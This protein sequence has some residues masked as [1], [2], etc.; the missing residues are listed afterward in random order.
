MYTGIQYTNN[1]STQLAEPCSETST[2]LVVNNNA[3]S[4]F[5]KLQNS[6]DY[7]TLTLADTNGN[8][9]I[10]KCIDKTDTTFTVVRAQEGTVAKAFPSGS[11]VE[12]RLTAFGLNSVSED[13]SK[14]KYHVSENAEEYGHATALTYSHAKITDNFESGYEAVDG[15]LLS[16]IGFTLAVN[17]LLSVPE[18]TTFTTSG[19]WVVPETG[20]YTVTAVGGGGKGGTGGN[21]YASCVVYS[22]SNCSCTNLGGGG[23]GGGGG[24]GETIITT[25]SLT[26]GTSITISIGAPN[27]GNTTFST[28]VTARGGSMGGTGGTAPT[29]GTGG[30]GGVSYGTAPDSGHVGYSVNETGYAAYGGTGGTGGNSLYGTYGIGGTGGTGG[31][32]SYDVSSCTNTSSAGSVGTNGIQGFLKIQRTW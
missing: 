29:G 13:A 12:N 5:P 30:T 27:G 31:T 3:T 1:A 19:T 9:E 24:A 18:V 11:L 10:V 22:E 14:V 7:F 4:I 17:R 2:V 26:K 21:G 20:T 23:G 6:S 15:V 32:G 25:V 8:V 28:L 16:P